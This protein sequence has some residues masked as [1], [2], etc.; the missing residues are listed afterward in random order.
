[1]LLSSRKLGPSIR[2]PS[3]FF[4]GSAVK[5]VWGHPLW[6][7]MKTSPFSRDYDNGGSVGT[8][9][10]S[11]WK[12]QCDCWLVV[13][14]FED[15]RRTTCPK[16]R[17]I[18]ARISKVHS[19]CR[20]MGSGL[21]VSSAGDE[22]SQKFQTFPQSKAHRAAQ[23]SG[24]PDVDFEQCRLWTSLVVCRPTTNNLVLKGATS[25]RLFACCGEG[26]G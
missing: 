13:L 14:L 24:K 9:R 1:M 16:G 7:K 3:W 6:W 19:R 26:S 12:H 2:C 17:T 5:R 22:P 11:S 25:R 4:R 18:K 15:I 10:V 8:P 21:N 20:Q 23:A